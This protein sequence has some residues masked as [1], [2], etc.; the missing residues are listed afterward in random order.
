MTIVLETLCGCS[1]V[2]EIQGTPLEEIALPIPVDPLM[3]PWNDGAIDQKFRARKFRRVGS[4][5][6]REV[7]D[8]GQ[9]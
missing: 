2:M 1:R 6:Y 7:P 8:N 9:R 5:H 4:T 3:R